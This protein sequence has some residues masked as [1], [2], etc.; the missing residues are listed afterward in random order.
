MLFIPTALMC[1]ASPARPER[2][3]ARYDALEAHLRSLPG[4]IVRLTFDEINRILGKRL[5]PSAYDHPPFWSNTDSHVHAVAW[6]RAGWRTVGHDLEQQYV[7]FRRFTAGPSGELHAGGQ[8][9]NETN[10]AEAPVSDSDR[11]QWE[12]EERQLATILTRRGQRDFR[13][14]LLCA[15]GTTCAVS[16]STVEP[17]LEAAHIVP[18][19]L[20]TN[21]AT[22]NGLL[23]RADIHTLFDLHMVA[24][25]ATGCVAVSRS[26]ES[27]EYARYRGRRL[28]A[29]PTGEQEQPS[30]DHLKYHH[31]LFLT[32][33]GSLAV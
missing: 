30:A 18:H 22:A 2:N 28:A 4:D 13:S 33:E 12:S 27:S 29:L 6:E 9:R 10:A 14:R 32:R 25:D 31:E 17:L 20:E 3:M 15:Y 16:G 24:V 26:L 23:L 5:P 1:R 11:H 7:D 21:Y 19:A 8:S